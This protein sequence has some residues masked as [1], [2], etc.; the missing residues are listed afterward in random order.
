[1]LCVNRKSQSEIVVIQYSLVIQAT[2]FPLHGPQGKEK[3]DGQIHV[4]EENVEPQSPEG[5]HQIYC[6]LGIL[7]L[8]W[9]L[10]QEQ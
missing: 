8:K 1:M 7:F 3:R 5:R 10:I 6:I 4:K 2:C 9:P